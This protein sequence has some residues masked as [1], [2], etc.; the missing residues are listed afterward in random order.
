MAPTFLRHRRQASAAAD[1]DGLRVR[2]LRVV[3]PNGAMGVD[4]VSFDAPPGRI[5][6]VLGRNGAG[7]T[8]LLTGIAGSLRG[9]RVTVTGSV[10]L[11]GSQI[12]GIGP[13]RA[14]RAGIVLVPERDKIFPSLTVT[15]NLAVV[16]PK[17]PGSR[18]GLPL[19]FPALE[20]RTESRAGMLSGGERQML[21]LSMAVVQRPCA[22][23][24]DELSLGLAP[25]IVKELMNA[26]RGMAD[27]LAIPVVVV[28]QD[29]VAA[30]KVADY[31]YVLDRGRIVWQGGANDISAAELGRRYLGMPA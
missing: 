20:R 27:S 12:A 7:K 2:D 13:V 19:R 4:S 21:A 9:E 26:L 31:L 5:V 3:Y 23:L 30:L 15:E 6:A 10:E 28:E 29:A 14:N 8:S 17:T 25:V 18:A 22:L 24:V 1:S 16:T 11:A